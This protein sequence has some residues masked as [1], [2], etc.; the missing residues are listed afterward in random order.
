[1]GIIG[2]MLS[3]NREKSIVLK[4]IMFYI[5]FPFTVLGLSGIQ[6]VTTIGF[7]GGFSIKID[8]K[9]NREKV[10]KSK[11]KKNSKIYRNS[12]SRRI[13]LDYRLRDV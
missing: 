7:V 4:T 12:Y 6:F 9:T 2:F 13:S 3:R 5:A 8:E 11:E 10:S 1:M